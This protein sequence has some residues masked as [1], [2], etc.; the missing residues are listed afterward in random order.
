ML[1]IEQSIKKRPIQDA[2]LKIDVLFNFPM[3]EVIRSSQMEN[4]PINYG[5]EASNYNPSG[6][7]WQV[8]NSP[9]M[10]IPLPT[11]K[12]IEPELQKLSQKVMKK[13]WDNKEDEFWDKY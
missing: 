10:T 6:N 5:W 11:S 3:K 7:A 1:E 13:T 9:Q 8:S 2:N 12:S 4:T